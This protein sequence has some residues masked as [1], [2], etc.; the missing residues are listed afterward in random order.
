M[1][2]RGF[3][4][5]LFSW[6]NCYAAVPPRQP[7][8]PILQGSALRSGSKQFKSLRKSLK[9]TKSNRPLPPEHTQA[10]ETRD[11]THCLKAHL[12]KRYW[13]TWKRHPSAH[14]AA[15]GLCIVLQVSSFHKGS[16]TCAGMGFWWCICLWV[17]SAP[18]YNLSHTPVSSLNKIHWLTKL[19]LGDILTLVCCWFLHQ[20]SKYLFTSPQEQYHITK[21]K[22]VPT[23]NITSLDF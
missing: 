3:L 18:V 16:S 21:I 13:A 20:V 9:L 15:C 23:Q 11:Q 6:G 14:W 4:V 8:P 10:K 5:F 7:P 22:Q 19:D 1:T 12:S 2:P 17:T